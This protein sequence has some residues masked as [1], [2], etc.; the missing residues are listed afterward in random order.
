M[1]SSEAEKLVDAVYD[2]AFAPA[3]WPDV[4]QDFPGPS[5]HR[6][7]VE[8]QTARD[9]LDLLTLALFVVDARAHVHFANRAAED[10]L[11]QSD[12]IH[13]G[14]LG[15]SASQTG[16]TKQLG[17]LVAQATRTG[18]EIAVGGAMTIERPSSKHAYQVLV[19]PL[20]ARSDWA[21]IAP[22]GAAAV[23]FVSDPDGAP[24]NVEAQLRT[25]YALTPAEARL[26]CALGAGGNINAVAEAMGVLPST[27]RTHL[28]HVFQ[29]TETRSQAELV[30]LVER[31]P[32]CR[33]QSRG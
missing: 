1:R 30:R 24:T 2:A 29:K 26:A 32:S 15:L 33:R 31:T 27:A 22:S 13:T 28:H 9:V 6:P 10:M 19:S 7:C 21:D 23:V 8:E 11:R 18:Q 4:L 17:A 14:P 25:F 12:G 16:Q 20:S 5:L 3:R